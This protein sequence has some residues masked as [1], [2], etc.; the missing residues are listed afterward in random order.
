MTPSK[1]TH[2]QNFT[3]RKSDSML[4][5]ALKLPLYR[6]SRCLVIIQSQ[7]VGGGPGSRIVQFGMYLLDSILGVISRNTENHADIIDIQ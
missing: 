1:Q 3:F 2:E 7:L 6:T 5:D 4:Q